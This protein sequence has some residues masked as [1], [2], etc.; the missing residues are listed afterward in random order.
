MNPFFRTGWLLLLIITVAAYVLG[1][2]ELVVAAW[3][4]RAPDW[5]NALV[6]AVYPRFLVEKH[7]FDLPFFLAKADQV[8]IRFTLVNLASWVLVSLFQQHA[9]FQQK[10][11][12]LV[13]RPVSVR[14]VNWLMALFFAGVIFFTY[15]WYGYLHNLHQ[16]RAFYKPLLL[17]RLLH[18]G[19]PAPSI[20][21][22]L[23]SLLLL[24]CVCVI[25]RISPVFSSV[26]AASLFVLL[27]AWLYSFEKM[28]HTFAPLTYAI[29]LMPFLVIG[30]Q[31]AMRENRTRKDS[32]EQLGWP[33]FL[34]QLAICLI[35]LQAGLE[36]LLIGGLDWLSPQTFRN[37]IYL[38]QA[39]AG[40]WV[41]QSEVLCIVLPFLALLFQLGF[42]LIVF[43]P[44][45]RWLF[46][47][48]GVI[49]HSGTYLL[50]GVGW[51]FN[52]WI[53]SYLFFIPWEKA[54]VFFRR[55]ITG[56]T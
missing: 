14:R 31:Q 22:A 18:L 53:Y 37:Y 50:L 5:F 38:H 41:A 47:P 16:A 23:C 1:L 49:F 27:Q 17:L 46:L 25:I 30:R 29:L 2:R 33:L 32:L 36:K 11:T 10:L 48:A 55:I 28:D 44:R 51:Y 9:G 39:P 45:F 43:F 12:D 42:V 24:S 54:A 35:Y 20:S 21:A 52:A 8:M 4:D 15:E 26:V 34:I 56:K 7:R 6:A 3:H 13:N 19:F 40:M